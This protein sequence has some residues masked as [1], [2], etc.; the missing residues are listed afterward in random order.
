MGVLSNGILSVGC[1]VI[2]F[3][4]TFYEATF[5][6]YELEKNGG[7]FA[8]VKKGLRCIELLGLFLSPFCTYFYFKLFGEDGMPFKSVVLL[9]ITCVGVLLLLVGLFYAIRK[10]KLFKLILALRYFIT[11]FTILSLMILAVILFI[12][13]MGGVCTVNKLE[14]IGFYPMIV[15]YCIFSNVALE[16]IIFFLIIEA[17]KF[18]RR[19]TIIYFFRSR[20]ILYLR[21]FSEDDCQYNQNELD[22]INRFAEELKYK[23]IKI[24]NPKLL[25]T[26]ATYNVYYLP[27]TNW[28]RHLHKMIRTADCI[29]VSLSKTEGLIWEVINHKEY[30]NKYIFS[31]SNIEILDFW[32]EYCISHDEP[33][34][35]AI[36]LSLRDSDVQF[37]PK[38]FFINN[39]GSLVC[40]NDI[41]FILNLH[42]NMS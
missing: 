34:F 29:Y 28:K 23:L 42:S 3:V 36:L 37:I 38:V 30:W 8:W 41:K 5:F 7:R 32:I 24:G 6:E 20:T 27:T 21:S 14:A 9:I 10:S 39:S 33:E 2:F 18:F 25:V 22:I 17:V 1:F 13:M 19:Q 26:N 35:L 4:F 40:N 15:G 31:L 16:F 12:I 11:L